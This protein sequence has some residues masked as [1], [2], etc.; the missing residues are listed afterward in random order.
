MLFVNVMGVEAQQRFPKP[1]FESGHTQPPTVTPQPRADFMEYVDVLVLII[2]LSIIT[3][4]IL[5]KRSRL[6]VFWTSIFSLIYFGFYRE[7]CVCSVGSLQNITLA[8]FNSDYDIPLTVILFF[9]IPIL[10]SLFFGR[11]FCAGICPLGAIQDLFIIKPISLKPWVNKMLGIFPWLYL[12]LAVLYAANATDFIICRYDPF[13]G[14]FRLDGT[15]LTYTLGAVFLITGTVIAR[16]YCRFLCPYG[17]IL[18]LSSRFSKKHLTISP[19]SCINC[20][21]CENSCPFDAIE[22]PEED[23]KTSDKQSLT[24]RYI[25]I[26]LIIP[27][28]MISMGWISSTLH[29]NFAAVHPKVK[30]ANMLINENDYTEEPVEIEA[31]KSSGTSKKELFNEALE[32]TNNFYYGSWILGLFIGLVI[33]LKLANLS[34]FR[35]KED[36]Q[37]NKAE[38]LSCGRCMDYCPVPENKRNV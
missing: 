20:K 34:L 25:R 10:Y 37:P 15:A 26:A 36:Y 1:E 7:G 3:W 22:I 4:F 18:N 32:I 33:G 9:S 13:I 31:F 23:I 35:I 30:L 38:C 6:G 24:K 14:I 19:S 17:A 12:G 28:I 8:L 16:P 29:E 11:T 27:L 2:S 21:L 5:R